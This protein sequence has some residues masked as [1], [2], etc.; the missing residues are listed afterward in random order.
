M[1]RKDLEKLGFTVKENGKIDFNNPPEGKMFVPIPTDE[2]DIKLRG[3]DR[4]FV[5][6][7]KFSATPVLVVMELIDDEENAGTK[8]YLTAMNTEYKELERKSRCMIRSPRTG[9]VIYCPESISCYS[10]ACPKKMGLEVMTS[11]D[12]P[13]DD[14]AETVK[15]SVCSLDPT[16]DEAIYNVEWALFKE[17]LRE[18]E[19]VLADIIEWDEYGL[20]RDEILKKL[21]RNK[22]ERSWYYYQWKRIRDRWEKYYKG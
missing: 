2:E 18:E 9:K 14:M 13:L 6:V 19:P 17:K 12:A 1:T 11:R 10:D 21:N 3:I 7:H 5:T 4:R 8:A 22:S 20:S 16:A 15:S